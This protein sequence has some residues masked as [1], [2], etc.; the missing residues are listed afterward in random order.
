[1]WEKIA[2]LG[3]FSTEIWLFLFTQFNK[4]LSC[5]TGVEVVKETK[6][7]EDYHQEK[8]YY[9]RHHILLVWENVVL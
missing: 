5:L 3:L 7:C 9:V 8:K 4:L 1:M 6:G 2:A